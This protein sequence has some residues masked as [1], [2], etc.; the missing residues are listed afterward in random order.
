MKNKAK[1]DQKLNRTRRGTVDAYVSAFFQHIFVFVTLTV[2]ILT[3]KSNKFILDD[4]NVHQSCKFGE[5]PPN[6]F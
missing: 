4:P 5:I 6:G 1:P 2:D 3:L